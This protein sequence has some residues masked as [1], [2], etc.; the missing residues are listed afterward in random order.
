MTLCNSGVVIKRK[1]GT[2]S[3]ET[4]LRDHFGPTNYSEYEHE[5]LSSDVRAALQDSKRFMT[6][7]CSDRGH[8][9]LQQALEERLRC[10]RSNF[11][12][13]VKILGG[14]E[15][16]IVDASCHSNNAR[17]VM[18][19]AMDFLH[20]CNDK[21]EHADSILSTLIASN[22]FE[23]KNKFLA[24]SYDATGSWVIQ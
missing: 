1:T 4:V 21:V 14:K 13:L 9:A 8:G 22:L 11:H 3:N 12:K 19:S 5:Q 24:L 23:C 16:D 7:W 2:K 10:N 15:F 17:N 18:R 20:R 6:M